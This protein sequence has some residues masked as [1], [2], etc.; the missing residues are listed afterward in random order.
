MKKNAKPYVIVCSGMTLD[1]KIS[2]AKRQQIQI[3]KSGCI[4]MLLQA[5]AEADAVVVGGNTLIQDDPGLSVKTEKYRLQRKNKGLAI[6]PAKVAIVTKLENIKLD[7]DFF[8]KG[9]RDIHIFTSEK[10]S[11]S[12]IN[13]LS[14]LANIIVCGKNK[15]NLKLMIKKLKNLD[16]KKLVVEGGGELNYSMFRN[17]MV[18]EVRLKVGNVI[19]GGKD[20]VTFVG[21]E[22]FSKNNMPSIEIL[23]MSKGKDHVIIHGKVKS[24]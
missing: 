9:S 22:G 13:R 14:K 5:R 1:G 12:S 18:D 19:A 23:K 4:D 8:N 11:K 15:V 10:S 3:D 16:Y 17:G 6:E 7:G 24:A 21:G 20:S 2:N